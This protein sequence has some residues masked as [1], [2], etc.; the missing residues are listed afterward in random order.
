MCYIAPQD[1][2]IHRATAVANNAVELNNNTTTHTI[3][4]DPQELNIHEP[5]FFL[6]FNMGVAALLPQTLSLTLAEFLYQHDIPLIQIQNDPH[7]LLAVCGTQSP[8]TEQ[9]FT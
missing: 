7:R 2:G 9:Y 8:V 6:Q 4:K 1:I 5:Q 3:F